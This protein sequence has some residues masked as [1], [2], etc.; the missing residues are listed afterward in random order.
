MTYSTFHLL[1]TL[2]ILALLG[3]VA[4]RTA[5]GRPADYAHRWHAWLF[6]S[7][8]AFIYTTP[9]D[10]YLVGQG[11]WGYPEGSVLGTVAG[12]PVEE[13]AFFLIQTA[14]TTLWFFI[15]LGRLR[16]GGQTLAPPPSLRSQ[17]RARWTLPCLGYLALVGVYALQFEQG[18]YFGLILVWACPILVLHWLVGGSWLADNLKLIAW[19]VLPPTLYFWVADWVAIYTGAWHIN[20]ALSLG[21]SLVGLPLE[22]AVFFLVTNIMVVQGLYLYLAVLE[23]WES[24]RLRLLTVGRRFGLTLEGGRPHVSR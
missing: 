18:T 22:E 24:V 12:V 7:V 4:W 19:G 6:L 1:F 14:I 20:P 23:Q 13:Y 9:W 2:P 16:P 10:I 3:V 8:I 5:K 15:C 21:P 17:Q 11:V